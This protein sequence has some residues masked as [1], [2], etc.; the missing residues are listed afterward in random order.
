MNIGTYSLLKTLEMV[1]LMMAGLPHKDF[2]SYLFDMIQVPAFLPELLQ[3]PGL[4]PGPA[5]DERSPPRPT[6]FTKDN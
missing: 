1:L 4:S 5:A 6:L 3:Q 2:L